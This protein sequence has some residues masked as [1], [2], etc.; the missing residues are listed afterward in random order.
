MTDITYRSDAT[1]MVAQGTTC[2]AWIAAW[3]GQWAEGVREGQQIA[4]RYHELSQLSGPDLARRGL[5]RQTIAR[6][7]LTGH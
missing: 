7:A 2:F 5:T 3:C 4:A 1:D 6:A